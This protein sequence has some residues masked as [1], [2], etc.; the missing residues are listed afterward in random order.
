MASMPEC[1]LTRCYGLTSSGSSVARAAEHRCQDVPPALPQER[2]PKRATDP[3]PRHSRQEST[4]TGTEL[5]CWAHDEDSAGT[6]D[7]GCFWASRTVRRAT[8]LVKSCRTSTGKTITFDT[9]SVTKVSYAAPMGPVTT[10]KMM[11][12]ARFAAASTPTSQ[13]RRSVDSGDEQGADPVDRVFRYV[14]QPDAAEQDVDRFRESGGMPGDET[15][16][17]QHDHDCEHRAGDR[18]TSV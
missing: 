16:R 6:A 4:P 14:R 18:H 15:H 1:A 5:E 17:R 12:G 11:V 10:A 8:P 13:T 2:E 7:G 9:M 3:P